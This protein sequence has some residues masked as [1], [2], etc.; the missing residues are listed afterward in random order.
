MA[1]IRLN[2]PLNF[3]RGIDGIVY[4]GPET[5]TRQ[6]PR[7]SKLPPSSE[8]V[9][10]KLSQLLAKPNTDDYL[11]SALQP[12]VPNELLAPGRFSQALSTALHDLSAAAA[13]GGQDAA[14]LNRAAQV[15]KEEDALRGLVSL[16][17]SALYQG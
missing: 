12:D 14:P 13:R 8:G 17:R 4:A 9:K 15:L 11:T 7:E 16:Y 6:L 5:V 10:T 1:D 2:S 3:N